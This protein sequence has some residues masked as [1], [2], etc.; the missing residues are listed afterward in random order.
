MRNLTNF[1]RWAGVIGLAASL[2]CKSLDVEN[3]NAPDAKRAF[4]DP[5]AVA[6]LVTGGFKGWWDAH[7]EYNSAL[8][9]STM[10]DGLTAS[11]NNFNIRYYSSEG[12][13]CPVRCGWDNNP[14]SAF[15]FQIET[16]WYGNYAAL[17]NAND[18]LTAIRTNHIQIVSAANT[19]LLEAAAVTLEGLVFS[20][21]G[22]N[23]DQGFI[24]TEATDLSTP[25]KVAALNFSTR[26]QMRDAAITKLGEA[27]TLWGAVTATSVPKEW[28]GKVN[29]PVYSPADMVRMIRTA[30][31]M[32]LAFYPRN[33]AENA[34]VNW[35]QVATYAS[36]GVSTGTV[37]I[38]YYDDRTDFYDGVKEWG[39]DPTTMRVDTRVA[40]LITD[41][42]Q[43]ETLRHKDPWPDPAGNP[44][45]D[46][47]DK[48]VG[49][50]TY[51]I[52]DDFLGA[53]T[54]KFSGH[55]GSDYL[56]AEKAQFRPARGQYHQSNLGYRR[57]SYL[58]YPGYGLPGED[59]KGLALQ[60]TRTLGDLLWAEGL[61]R[62]GGSATQAATLLNKTRVT[63]GGLSA[64]TGAETQAQLLTALQY[65]QDIELLGTSG[66]VFFNR[67][68]IDGLKSGTPRHMPVP[69]KELQV[70]QKEL[71]TFGGPGKPDFAP[72]VDGNG[73]QVRNVRAIWE[74]LST[75]SRMEAK[76]RSRH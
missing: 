70:L 30:Q 12:N 41:G 59:G 11:W 9:L 44:Q 57:Y 45:P 66:S 58:A 72:G 34:Q 22:T 1:A 18:V 42:P 76:R 3:P 50:G 61:I 51:G 48:R 74:E 16:Y 56:Y 54:I 4:A 67:R 26:V 49:D 63:R 8:L 43:G 2:G 24:V 60:F 15:R 19:K 68:R 28:F 40:R 25:E 53:G 31:A 39:A 10:A 13:E 17:S 46:A 35:S 64:L 55:E 32:T 21:I 62:G 47:F 6:G 20:E 14:S 33:A 71:Y 75:A 37:D 65:E 27:A 69:A 7:S 36:Q 73:R 5:S 38:G 23:Y 29:Q 52:D